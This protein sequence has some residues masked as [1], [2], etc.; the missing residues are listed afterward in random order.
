LSGDDSRSR[1]PLS[2]SSSAKADGKADKSDLGKSFDNVPQ[3]DIPLIEEAP[4]PVEADS[5]QIKGVV[6]F[7]NS[8]AEASSIIDEN[9][10]SMQRDNPEPSPLNLQLDKGKSH[11]VTQD[12]RPI[13]KTKTIFS[14]KKEPSPNLSSLE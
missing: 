14:H 10:S 4:G 8:I 1:V 11:L 6:A 7:N 5:P 9:C 12:L 3:H 13:N 2:R